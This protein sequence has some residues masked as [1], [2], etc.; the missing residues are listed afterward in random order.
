MT[1]TLACRVGRH[2]WMQQDRSTLV[3][4][5]CGAVRP[6]RKTLRCYL[7]SH[8]W[9][10]VTNEGQHYLECARCGRYGGGPAS[11]SWGRRDPN[12]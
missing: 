2:H 12:L 5:R 3:C 4:R 6:R 11:F 1:A 9:V 10:S 7:G 8:H